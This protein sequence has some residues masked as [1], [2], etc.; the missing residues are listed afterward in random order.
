MS[1]A[2]LNTAAGRHR[3]AWPITVAAILLGLLT[4]PY[5]LIIWA[6]A[7]P[8]CW[9]LFLRDAAR[10]RVVV[11]YDVNDQAATWFQDLVDNWAWLSNSHKLWRTVQSGRVQTVYQHKN[12]A[13]ASELVR[14]VPVTATLKGPPHLATNVA[15][16][17]TECRQV[18]PAL[19]ARPRA[20]P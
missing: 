12:N 15:V 18:E 3:L 11:F 16:P 10:R 19:P 5:G 14:R 4:L 6:I 20:R 8:I 2:Q 9:W 1:S 13:G 7:A 17:H